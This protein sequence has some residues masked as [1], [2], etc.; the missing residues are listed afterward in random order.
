M[1][2]IDQSKTPQV[3]PWNPIQTLRRYDSDQV[4]FSGGFLRSR[5]ER[6]FPGF[7][8]H[9]LPLAHALGI[10][11]QLVEIK[12]LLTVPSGLEYL[13]AASV[14]GGK[15]AIG[16]D[17]E[18]ALVISQAIAPGAREAAA[19]IVVEY[20][21]RRFLSTSA[22]A[23]SGEDAASVTF[24]SNR[25]PLATEYIGSIKLTVMVNSY[26]CTVWTALDQTLVSQLDG[27]W[28]RQVNAQAR[29]DL[30]SG[31]IQVEIGQLGVEPTSIDEYVRAGAIVDLEA[32]ISDMVILRIDGK[33]WL[34]SKLGLIN[35]AF[36]FESSSMPLLQAPLADNLTHISVQLGEFS[37]SPESVSELTQPGSVVQSAL[38]CGNRVL[39]V[40]QQA[41]VA[42][43][44]LCTFDGR[45][46]VRIDSP[47]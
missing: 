2:A 19:Q 21:M 43:G 30:S 14:A 27:L 5:P 8:A 1:T 22:M 40:V 45:W 41:V 42:E 20:V 10:E 38:T 31:L 11:A 24:S 23:W 39:L 17:A 34:N 44:T 18:S 15:L 26:Y 9:W 12:P 35:D 36:A 13:Y 6:W 29:S 37:L 3:V 7:S 25:D 47:A 28:K 4:R 33:P 32:A 46:A 16:I